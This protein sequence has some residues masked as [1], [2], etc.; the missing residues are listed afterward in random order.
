MRGGAGRGQREER[1]EEDRERKER[2]KTQGGGRGNERW[3]EEGRKK[4]KGEGEE[5]PP[6]TQ[7]PARQCPLLKAA[8]WE[9]ADEAFPLTPQWSETTSFSKCFKDPIPP[10]EAFWGPWYIIHRRAG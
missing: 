7:T 1:E 3:Q 8:G 5:G 9:V 4:R 6:L 2:E 10:R